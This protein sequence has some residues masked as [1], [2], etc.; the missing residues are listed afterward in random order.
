MTAQLTRDQERK[1]AVGILG[2][3]V[4]LLSLLVIVPV[5][6]VNANYAARIDQLQL[7]L[8]SVRSRA[9]AD[10]VLRRP[11]PWSARYAVVAVADRFVR[12]SWR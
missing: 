1:L 4:V 12:H 3:A 6:N 2:I 11:P 5:W 7:R 8:H 10:A 9:A